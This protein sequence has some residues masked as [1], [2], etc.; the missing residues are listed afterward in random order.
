VLQALV[1]RG[2]P[3]PVR[4]HRVVAP[5]LVAHLDLAWPVQ[6]LA[7]ECDSEAY[8]MSVE[9][10]RWDRERQNRLVLLGWTVLRCTYRDVTTRPAW[11]AAQVL[12]ALRAP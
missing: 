12:Q 11:L 4:Q 5:G 2:V 7:L 9:Q 3:A 10:F 6:R 8:H 1:A